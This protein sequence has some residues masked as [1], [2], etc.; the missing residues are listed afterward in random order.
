MVGPALMLR[1]GPALGTVYCLSGS[2]G[3]APAHLQALTIERVM[4]NDAHSTT[5]QVAQRGPPK[6]GVMSELH[7]RACRRYCA[8]P[9][10]CPRV[11]DL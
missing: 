7:A 5:L 1:R 10:G 3:P 6:D 9:C 2:S 8:D 4:P 11:E